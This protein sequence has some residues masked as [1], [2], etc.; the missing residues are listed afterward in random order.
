M[1][2]GREWALWRTWSLPF[3]FFTQRRSSFGREHKEKNPGVKNAAAFA[4]DLREDPSSRWRYKA[5]GSPSLL[6]E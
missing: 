2:W 6:R 5:S 3:I 1:P 4:S